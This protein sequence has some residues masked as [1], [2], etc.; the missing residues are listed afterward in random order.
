MT[1]P[2]NIT[3]ESM[4]EAMPIV[5]PPQDQKAFDTMLAEAEADLKAS[6]FGAFVRV[7]MGRPRKAEAA[8]P[9][10]VK[11]V[12]LPVALLEELQGAARR[13][14]LSLNAVLQ[15]ASAEWLTHHQGH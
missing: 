9:S 8:A 12:R 15:M 11:A 4:L 6:N 5:A 13:Q 2:K 14:G 1:K 10:V 7:K 3:L